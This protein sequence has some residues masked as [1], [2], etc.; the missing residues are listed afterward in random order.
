M[1]LWLLLYNEK[2]KLPG[3][4]LLSNDISIIEESSAPCKDDSLSC[5]FKK[6]IKLLKSK[7]YKQAENLNTHAEREVYLGTADIKQTLLSKGWQGMCRE[8]NLL[9]Q[10]I[11]YCLAP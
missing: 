8:M 2:Y 11:Y 3:S 10:Y 5:I 4:L 1:E 9:S 6:G 7:I